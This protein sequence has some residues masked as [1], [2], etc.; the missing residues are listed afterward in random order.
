MNKLMERSTKFAMSVAK[1][2]KDPSVLKKSPHVLHVTV[3]GNLVVRSSGKI[4]GDAKISWRIYSKT[5]H[6]C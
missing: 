1:I 6:T 4:F 3:L 5:S 2:V